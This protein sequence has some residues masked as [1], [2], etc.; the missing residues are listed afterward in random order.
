M[1]R[2][3]ASLALLWL[4]TGCQA[5]APTAG[6]AVSAREPHIQLWGPPDNSGGNSGGSG[7]GG[8]GGM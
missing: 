2:L 7:G 5:G 3:I 6:A 1:V 4:L 8:G